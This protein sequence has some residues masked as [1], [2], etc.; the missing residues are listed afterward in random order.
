MNYSDEEIKSRIKPLCSNLFELENRLREIRDGK[1]EFKFSDLESVFGE[2]S[3]VVE[4]MQEY[5]SIFEEEIKMYE[6]AKSFF[7]KGPR[8]LLGAYLKEV[9]SSNSDLPF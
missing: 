2:I 1:E 8:T 9:W 4:Q 6:G 7:E 3:S 5:P